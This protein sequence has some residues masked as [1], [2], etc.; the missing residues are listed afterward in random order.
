VIVA[1]ETAPQR[2]DGVMS[3]LIVANSPKDWP[4]E[5]PGVEIVDAWDYL[6]QSEFSDLRGAKVLNLCRSYSYQ[7]TGY[8][9]SLLAEARGHKPIPSIQTLQDIRSQSIIRVVSDDLD[10]LVQSS[11][12]PLH[13][14]EFELSV[15]FGRNMAKRYD[16]LALQLFN[17]FQA[18]LIRVKFGKNKKW[19]IRSVKAISGSDVPESHR[20]FVAEAAAKHFSGRAVSKPKK[21]KTRYDLAILWDATAQN[22]PSDEAA[23]KKFIKVG[24]SMGIEVEIIS[25]DDYGRLMEFDALFIRETTGINDHTYRFAR[26]AANEGLVVIDDPQSIARCTNKVFLAELMER[27]EIPT[28]K[29][30]VMHED[31]VDEVIS[32]LGF[33][34]VL[35]KPDSAFS[36]GVVKMKS[37]EELRE[38]LKEFFDD[39]ELLVAQEF[40]PTDFDWRIGILD[41]RPLF[42]CK[43]FMAPGHWQIIQH[44]KQGDGRY[45]KYE[46]LP[47]ELAPRKA[48][49]MALKAA[50]LI[51]DGL[52]GVDVKQSGG[53]FYIIEVNDNPNIEQ[54]VEDSVLRDELYHRI[55][56]VFL[57]RLERRRAWVPAE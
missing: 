8:Y 18:P 11:L 50:N 37:E 31:N 2:K 47:V 27:H 14:E 40:L 16:R 9:V 25:K 45:G 57:A 21:A 38:R 56:S 17:L 22:T 15:Y 3:T 35:K 53:N 23:L 4:F 6:T 19:S 13:S 48:V 52:Y 1:T 20:P 5:I 30:L 26:A 12:E 42:A 49:S 28:P 10:D 29:T 33:P 43:Y 55:M 51:G 7:S 36:Q 41:R 54:G 32:G 24:S 39:S 34:M 46:T 44:E